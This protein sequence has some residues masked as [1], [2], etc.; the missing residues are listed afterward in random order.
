MARAC[1][2][3]KT[4]RN[5]LMNLTKWVI[6]FSC[7][8]YSTS[9]FSQ[10]TLRVDSL[11]NLEE[12]IITFRLNQ[13]SP[14]SYSELSPKQL[15]V[16]NTGQEPSF[17]LSRTPGITNYSDAG[18][19]Q[20]YSYFRI[21]GIDQTRVNMTI[22]GVPMNEPED[23]GAY[24]S[25]YP[26]V[27]RSVESV[28]IQR[29]VGISKNGVASYA[30]SIDMKTTTV[31]S[32]QTTIGVG[33]GS[34]NTVRA[35]A[36]HQQEIN[37]NSSF[38]VRVS[39]VYSDGYKE[40]SGNHS[41]SALIGG[42]VKW[43]RHKLKIRSILGHQ[44]N[45]MAWL[46]VS[47]SLITANP[48]HNANSEENDEFLQSMTYV[49]LVSPIKKRG[50]LQSS[51]YYT[52]L[53]GN[54]DFDFNNFLGLPSTNELYNYAFQS[55]F[56]GGFLN[57]KWAVNTFRLTTGV[58]ANTY[59]R[60]HEGSE[61]SLGVL[62]TNTGFKS[63]QSAFVKLEKSVADFTGFADV[64]YRRSTFSYEGAVEMNPIEW[65]FL[66]PKV[67]LTYQ[68][69]RS[70]LYYSIGTTSREPTRNDMFGGNDDLVADS[71]GTAVLFSTEAESVLDQELGYRFKGKKA[72]VGLNVYYMDFRNEIVLNGNFGPNGLALTQNV[73]NS[74]RTGAELEL[75]VKLM[76][77][78]TVSSASALNVCRIEEGGV[79]FQ[80]ILSPLLISFNEVTYTFKSFRVAL[81]ARYQSESY[82]DFANTTKLDQYVLLGFRASYQ[83]KNWMAHIR[84]NNL[85]NQQYFNHG[86]VDYDGTAKY[87]IQNPIGIFGG[88]QVKF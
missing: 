78:L 23:Q 82:I 58:H 81:N 11:Q 86:Y 14:F 6:S 29:G 39:E 21:R 17:I 46:G 54:Y 72:K 70:S 37:E 18:S 19:D 32:T 4:K 83:F 9:V 63:E 30:G 43:K 24:F 36:E 38:Q 50:V 74:Y 77:N 56:V 60:E 1:I 25:N 44:Q 79:T 34:W 10:D 62:Y 61:R 68:K 66:I 49:Q 5:I 59:A 80:P 84:I 65:N 75:E 8:W 3:S 71:T 16:L 57:Y 27:L 15:N 41:Q 69:R 87:F 42:D 2:F 64:Q 31:D 26:D 28:Q 51:V 88:I 40:R 13:S 33:F 35:F 55:H 45:Q 20:G 12:T 67:G 76:E 47:D 73:E 85:T 48:R 7:L 52:F 22:D 53:N